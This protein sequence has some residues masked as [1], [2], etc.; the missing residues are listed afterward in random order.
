MLLIAESSLRRL[1][2]P[3]LMKNV[4]KGVEYKDGIE[5]TREEAAA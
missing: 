1:N 3:E 2:A 5:A 4:Y